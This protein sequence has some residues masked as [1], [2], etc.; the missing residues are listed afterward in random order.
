MRASKLIVAVLCSFM[1][2]GCTGNKN[3]P[4]ETV[5]VETEDSNSEKID[6]SK[7]T[8]KNLVAN[9]NEIKYEDNINNIK[10]LE[11]RNENIKNEYIRGISLVKKFSES[12]SISL[13]YEEPLKDRI[14]RFRDDESDVKLLR[15]LEQEGA[16]TVNY[17]TNN[18]YLNADLSIG[19]MDV[20]NNDKISTY[21]EIVYKASVGNIN[22]EFKFKDSKLNEFRSLI[23]QDN[24]LDLDKLDKFIASIYNNEQ[25]IDMRFF[26]KIDN[27][28]YE[29]IRVEKNNCYYRLI[30]DPLM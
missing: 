7:E 10:N 20:N 27:N 22:N 17:F 12:N 11:G 13:T 2:I 16:E 3:E 9:K 14:G 23:V 30:Y 19:I 8:F 4:E 15:A 6:D 18:Q 5:E 25:T 1:L 28:T 21:S 24:N 29:V 26:N